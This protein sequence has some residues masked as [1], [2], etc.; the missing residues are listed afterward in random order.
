MPINLRDDC[1]I[2]LLISDYK[3]AMECLRQENDTDESQ[4]FEAAKDLCEFTRGIRLRLGPI[5]RYESEQIRDLIELFTSAVGLIETLLKQYIENRSDDSKIGLLKCFCENI[6]DRAKVIKN[7][8]HP[9][10]QLEIVQADHAEC[11]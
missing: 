4:K 10:V 9:D 6:S 5:S 8:L 3:E 7:C 1:V 11:V 2:Q